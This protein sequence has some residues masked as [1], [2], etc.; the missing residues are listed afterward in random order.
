MRKKEG[1]VTS[2]PPT[3]TPAIVA[4]PKLPTTHAVVP[5]LTVIQMPAEATVTASPIKKKKN[6]EGKLQEYV[7]QHDGK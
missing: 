2:V 5:S 1:V 3:A 4:Q 7:G 6:E